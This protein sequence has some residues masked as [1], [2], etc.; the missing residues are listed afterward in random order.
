MKKAAP[1]GFLALAG[2]AAPGHYPAEG[3]RPSFSFPVTTNHTPYSQCLSEL[4]TTGGSNLPSFAVGEIADKTGQFRSGVNHNSTWSSQGIAEMLMSALYKT[5]KARL[6]ERFDLRIPLAQLKMVEQN[7][8]P[9]EAGPQPGMIRGS[10]FVILGALTELNYNIVSEGARLAISGIGG[11]GRSVIMNVGLDLRV[12]NSRTFDV[13]Y[14]TSLQKQIHGYEVEANVFRFFGTQLVE[15]DAGR[16]QNEPL[17]LGIRS[18]VEMA[19]YQ[20]MT[21]FL[22]LPS[23]ED[24]RVMETKFMDGYLNNE[25]NN[26]D[27]S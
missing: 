25:R 21:D 22:G 4:G 16:I 14:V 18:V 11:G 8:T 5:R 27:L 17:Q 6:V 9:R 24:C 20:I 10:D 23:R 15:F 3:V 19:A 12:V 7:L 2:C 26:H 1:L 13:N